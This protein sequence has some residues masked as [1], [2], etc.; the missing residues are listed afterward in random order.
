MVSLL[1]ILHL[2]LI[3][4]AGMSCQPDRVDLPEEILLI[5]EFLTSNKSC[6]GTDDAGDC[7]DWIELYNS[8]KEAVSL[9]EISCSDDSANLYKYTFPD[10]SLAP[11]AFIVLWA[12]DEPEEGAL[13]APFK[14][15]SEN[16]DEIILTGTRG[17]V[18]D[19]IQFFPH[20]GNPIARVPDASYGREFDGSENWVQL[21]SPSPGAKNTGGRK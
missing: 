4:A 3:I 5:N 20:S 19:R 7:D 10:T 18:L 13:H 2:C 14:L 9:K 1:S 15:S 12:D 16:G 8:G 17:K 11:G 6:L 21:F